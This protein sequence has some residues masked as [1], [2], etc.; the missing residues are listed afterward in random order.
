MSYTIIYTAIEGS[1]RQFM[2]MKTEQP[3]TFYD[4]T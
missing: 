4:R 1:I 3:P 2:I